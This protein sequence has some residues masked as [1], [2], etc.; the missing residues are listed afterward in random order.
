MP[1]PISMPYN[2]F[3][4]EH[5]KLIRVLESNNRKQM[6]DEAKDQ[7]RELAKYLKRRQ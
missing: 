5:K 2:A 1:K 7:K 3:V 4:S 6:R